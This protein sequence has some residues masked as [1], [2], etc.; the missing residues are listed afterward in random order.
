M[1]SLLIM[2][3]I[4]GLLRDQNHRC[5]K[6]HN[7]IKEDSIFSSLDDNL[8]SF[9]V[10]SFGVLITKRVLLK[11][12]LGVICAGL[13]S[14]A[15]EYVVEGPAWYLEGREADL[16][17]TWNDFVR[18]CGRSD[19]V[20]QVIKNFEKKYK[21]TVIEW[22]GH[23]MRVDGDHMES[24]DAGESLDIEHD[25]RHYQTHSAAEIMI[26][27]E[28]PL[29]GHFADSDYDLLLVLD[30]EHF[31]KYQDVLYALRVGSLVKFKGF[32]RNLGKVS[33]MGQRFIRVGRA[34]RN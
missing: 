20:D 26:R 8:V 29:R 24:D 27:M 32:L 11:L 10:G 12:F 1:Y 23:V 19:S 3:C 28:A 21:N 33:D 14:V 25:Q 6:C 7:E 15:Y 16:S 22:Q 13:A 18:D 9:N 31:E 17:I 4:L 2:P 34:K 30:S 5:P